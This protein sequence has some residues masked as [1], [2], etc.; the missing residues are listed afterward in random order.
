VG[1]VG[2]ASARFPS[3][4][5]RVLGVHGCGTGHGLSHRPYS[6][7]GA[8]A[9]SADRH[10]W[11]RDSLRARSGRF[12]GVRDGSQRWRRLRQFRQRRN[13]HPEYRAAEFDTGF[14]LATSRRAVD[15]GGRAIRL[16]LGVLKRRTGPERFGFNGLHEVQWRFRPVSVGGIW[17]RWQVIASTPAPQRQRPAP[18][19]RS[20]RA[21]PAPAPVPSRSRAVCPS[22]APTAPRSS[23]GY[24]PAPLPPCPA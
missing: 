18:R 16:P 1:G 15:P 5:G 17:R 22:P 7:A 6:L 9:R 12:R 21:A 4:G 20:P 2:N 8:A 13:N 3:S 24:R 19:R 23:S 11:L 14:F 10:R